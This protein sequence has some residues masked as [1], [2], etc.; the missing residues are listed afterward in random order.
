[1]ATCTEKGHRQVFVSNPLL[2]I[3]KKYIHINV[4]FAIHFEAKEF[5]LAVPEF[6]PTCS[7]RCLC[8]Q[9]ESFIRILE[10]KYGV[11]RYLRQRAIGN[12][13]LEFMK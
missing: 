6:L 11:W 8:W 7:T 2:G 13:R 4:N 3:P 9:R 1:M 12:A 10:H 5:N